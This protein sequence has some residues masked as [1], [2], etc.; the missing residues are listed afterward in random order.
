MN[1]K[2]YPYVD[3]YLQYRLFQLELITVPCCDLSVRGSGAVVI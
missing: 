1:Y 3:R 2:Q